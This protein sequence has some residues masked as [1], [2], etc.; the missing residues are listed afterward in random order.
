MGIPLKEVYEQLFGP[1]NKN[2]DIIFVPGAQFIVSR[3]KIHSRPKDF[4]LQIIKLLE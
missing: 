1:T 3:D 2:V 4:Y